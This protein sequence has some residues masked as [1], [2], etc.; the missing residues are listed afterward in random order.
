MN[1]QLLRAEQPEKITTSLTFNYTYIHKHTPHTNTQED[2]MDVFY[3]SLWVWKECDLYLILRLM[4]Y[5]P[6]LIKITIL[7]LLLMLFENF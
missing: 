2:N 6:F 1:L 3:K 7:S 5:I 4:T